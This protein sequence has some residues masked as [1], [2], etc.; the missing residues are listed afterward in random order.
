MMVF[1]DLLDIATYSAYIVYTSPNPTWNAVK[2]SSRR[3]FIRRLGKKL[4]V[5][6]LTSRFRFQ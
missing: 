1:Y 4:I 6:I 3:L 2:T 5:D